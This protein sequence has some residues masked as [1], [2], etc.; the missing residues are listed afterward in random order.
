MKFWLDEDERCAQVVES[1][2]C[3]QAVIAARANPLDAILIDFMLGDGTADACI[4][5]LRDAQPQARIVVCTANV[6][7]A[8]NAGVVALG[9]DAVV[10]KMAVVVEDVVDLV[11]G[12]VADDHDHIARSISRR[13][14]Y[15]SHSFR[16]PGR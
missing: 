15:S 5:A 6:R 4:P 2:S 13:P 10:E 11:L 9:A 8:M 16:R 3:A 7:G 14:P 1:E 12:S